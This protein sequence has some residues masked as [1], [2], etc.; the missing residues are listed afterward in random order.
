MLD[1]YGDLKSTSTAPSH[2]EQDTQDASAEVVPQSN[3]HLTRVSSW[4]MIVTE[5]GELN[6]SL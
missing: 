3:E 6:I 2:N 4:R 1:N 5:R